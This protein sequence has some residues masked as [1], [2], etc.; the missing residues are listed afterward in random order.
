MKNTNR[1]AE[2]YRKVI[3]NAIDE[4]MRAVD[5]GDDA[6]VDKF[7]TIAAMRMMDLKALEEQEGAG[8]R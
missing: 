5:D 6:A 4:A 7:T 8:L 3:N 2:L 1:Q